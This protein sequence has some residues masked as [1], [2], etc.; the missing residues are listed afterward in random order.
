MTR[1]LPAEWEEQDGVLLAWPHSGTDWLPHLEHVEPVFVEITRRI[2]R[3]E[4][5]VIVAEDAVEVARK[6]KSGGAAMERVAVFQMEL[7]DTWARDFGPITLLENDKPVILDF[8]FNGWGLKFPANHDNR[9]TRRLHGMGAFGRSPL[10]T[11]GFVLEGGSIESDGAGTI[12][13]TARCLLDANRNPHLSEREIER[14][15]GELLGADRF[16][17]LRNGHL[18]GDDT[19]SHIDTLARF[20]PGDTILHLSCDDPADEHYDAIHDMVEE[21]KK[22][23]TRNGKPYR[24][25]PLPWP[26]PSYDE[27][28][29]RLPATYANFLVIN[30]AVLVP[31]Y[32]NERD[33]AAREAIGGAFPDRVI[34]AVPCGPLLVQ[35]GSLHC[36]TM[37]I[38]K[39]ALA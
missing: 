13:T 9:I 26:A 38:P 17:W 25:I 22:F 27:N 2:G 5:V 31:T 21:L 34:I 14:L 37:Q 28:G 35:H 4:R 19:D 30:G 3:F 39:G 10:R 8:G 33:E 1:R 7:N 23:R 32:R 15:L 36:L 18:A 29:R 11:V 12:L 24:L 6:L 16:L 20:A